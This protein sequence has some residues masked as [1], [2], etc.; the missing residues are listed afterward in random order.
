MSEQEGVYRTQC[1]TH[2]SSL[3]REPTNKDINVIFKVHNPTG[4]LQNFP[5]QGLTEP[6]W[7]GHT[8]VA[9]CAHG[10]DKK[11]RMF[12]SCSEWSPRHGWHGR[13]TRLCKR[14]RQGMSVMLTHPA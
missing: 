2:S 6:G 5:L 9:R 14:E 10:F 13:L 7:G 4:C 3:H 1:R 11:R 12:V 8:A